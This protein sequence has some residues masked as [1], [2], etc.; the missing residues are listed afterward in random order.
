M[1]RHQVSTKFF[2]RVFKNNFERTAQDQK[3]KEL[4]MKIME[5]VNAGRV[6]NEI[7]PMNQM[8]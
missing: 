6:M 8:I 4:G 5:I 7:I 1:L 2:F 3:I